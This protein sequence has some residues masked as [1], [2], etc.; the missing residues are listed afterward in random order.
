M[1]ED[2]KG[3]DPL[4]KLKAA[5]STGDANVVLL[6]AVDIGLSVE[7]FEKAI[8]ELALI[9]VKEYK[10]AAEKVGSGSID[11]VEHN[12]MHIEL[13]WDGSFERERAEKFRKFARTL[14]ERVKNR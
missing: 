13:S 12:G 6:H 9:K 3:Q 11:G 10:V 5:I 2:T 4:D 1:V 14:A 7:D 8:A